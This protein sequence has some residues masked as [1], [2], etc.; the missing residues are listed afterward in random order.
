MRV[1]CPTS[2]TNLVD[3]ALLPLKYYHMVQIRISGKGKSARG[4]G[5]PKRE[6]E[7]VVEIENTARC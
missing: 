6:V 1:P 3:L 5:Y 4:L 2:Y 7:L